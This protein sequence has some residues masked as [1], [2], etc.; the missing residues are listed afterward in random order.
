[1]S[2]IEQLFSVGLGGDPKGLLVLLGLQPEV[3]YA[4]VFAVDG[5][6]YRRFFLI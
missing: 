6:L 2:A 1:M 4:G 5:L 3:G